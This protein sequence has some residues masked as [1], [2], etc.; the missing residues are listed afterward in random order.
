MAG[1]ITMDNAK[2]ILDQIERLPLREQ[3]LIA[4]ALAR[5]LRYVPPDEVWN[6]AVNE[7]IERYKESWE[8]LARR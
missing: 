6:T 4:A 7:I 8:E 2:R 5:K 3:Q 1:V